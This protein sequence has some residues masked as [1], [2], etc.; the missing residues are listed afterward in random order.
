MSKLRLFIENQELELNDD[1][2]FNITKQFED[3]SNPTVMINDW[4]KTVSIPFS[5]TNNKIFGFF[6]V[7]DKYTAPSSSATP[8]GINFDP[9]KRLNFRL[10]DGDSVLMMG[11]AKMNSVTQQDGKGTYNLTLN[12]QLGNLFKELQKINFDYH[13]GDLPEDRKYQIDTTEYFNEPITKELVY[14]CWTNV[15]NNLNSIDEAFD[16]THY[17]I[18]PIDIMGFAPNNAKIEGFDY[19]TVDAF[20]EYEGIRRVRTF[21]EII[22][23]DPD[24]TA[25]LNMTGDA[26]LPNGLTPREFGDY[27]AYLQLPYCY[28]HILWGIFQNKAEELTGYKFDLD[29]RWF[30]RNNPYWRNLAYMLK[31]FDAKSTQKGVDS[32]N[33]RFQNNTF[34][35]SYGS[36]PSIYPTVYF[37]AGQQLERQFIYVDEGESARFSAKIP[38]RFS[39]VNTQVNFDRITDFRMRNFFEIRVHWRGLHSQ[40]RVD[41]YLVT[42]SDPRGGR[43]DTTQ[44]GQIFEWEDLK[45]QGCI[46]RVEGSPTYR[47]NFVLTANKF[48]ERRDLADYENYVGMNVEVVPINANGDVYNW[49]FEADEKR[50]DGTKHTVYF[51]TTL[52][53]LYQDSGYLEVGRFVSPRDRSTFFSIKDFWNSEVKPFDEILRYCKM[54]NIYVEVDDVVKKIKFIQ[55]NHYFANYINDI[56]DWTDKVDYSQDYTLE[57]ARGDKR[58]LLFNYEDSKVANNENYKTK[59]GYNYGEIRFNTLNNFNDETESLFKGNKINIVSTPNVLSWDYLYNNFNLMYLIPNESFI[60]CADKDNKIV[61]PFGTFYF[62]NGIKNFD[63]TEGMR[64]PWISVD[65]YEQTTGG[66]FF[67]YETEGGEDEWSIG[68]YTYP[69]LTTCL[70]NKFLNFVLPTENYSVDIVYPRVNNADDVQDIYHLLWQQYLQERYSEYNKKF[71]CY[72]KLNKIDYQKFKFN[73][74]V[75]INNVLYLVNKIFDYNPSNHTTKVELLSVDNPKGY[76]NNRLPYFTLDEYEKNFHYYPGTT[77]EVKGS[78]KVYSDKPFVLLATENLI[79]DNITIIGDTV[80]YDA[81][82]LGSNWEGSITVGQVD[83]Y[84]TTILAETYQIHLTQH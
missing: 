44:Y 19:N 38:L 69:N 52:D 45:Q 50:S 64:I 16:G 40:E 43:L 1:V 27:R 41:K 32:Y 8:I 28:W 9:N 70:N 80:S 42:G 18:H 54:F 26:V 73:H 24:R 20:D 48:F 77:I 75:K 56:E 84:G 11:Y 12:G 65:T 7:I 29:K 61:D 67:Y 4:S 51:Q 82:L 34:S 71:T 25:T 57:S 47:F 55:K 21:T 35:I 39:F 17:N 14:D 37:K 53:F 76:T 49:R 10:Q 15:G 60:D 22:D 79:E 74:F 78:F 58:Y 3:L 33:Q 5:Q 83:A 59:Y 6:N 63:I 36:R 68:V 62:Y 2:Q 30:N 81:G 66:N 23:A 31:S 46:Y 72:I 13:Y